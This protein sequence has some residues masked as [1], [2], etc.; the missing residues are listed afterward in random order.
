MRRK[1]DLSVKQAAM[2]FRNRRPRRIRMR[3][4]E[5][6]LRF[7][8]LVYSQTHTVSETAAWLNKHDWRRW[9]ISG[10]KPKA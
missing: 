10:L 7:N 5:S 6:T 8:A 4:S 2:R 3:F 1:V 9:L